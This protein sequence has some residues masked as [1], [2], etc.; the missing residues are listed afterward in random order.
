MANHKGRRSE[1]KTVRGGM[2]PTVQKQT[3]TRYQ[4]SLLCKKLRHTTAIDG[5]SCAQQPTHV[6]TAQPA[7]KS[8][9]PRPSRAVAVAVAAAPG[10]A[11]EAV[12]VA[13][14]EIKVDV[15]DA[16]AGAG[17]AHAAEEVGRELD[18]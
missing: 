11:V 17:A 5:R 18:L 3:T 15:D 6:I 1:R 16:V 4:L 7:I 10:A 9:R 14:L 12:A 8:P 13:P 2:R